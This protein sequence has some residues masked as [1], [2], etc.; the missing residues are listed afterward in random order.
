M[1]ECEGPTYRGCGCEWWWR[2]L[3]VCLGWGRG[4]DGLIRWMHGR[5]GSGRLDRGRRGVCVGLSVRGLRRQWLLLG[6]VGGRRGAVVGRLGVGMLRGLVVA[7]WW[8]L[9]LSTTSGSGGGGVEVLGVWLGRASG[10]HVGVLL[11]G[12]LLLLSGW[13]RLR[14]QGLGV[15]LRGRRGR[16]G[17]W[18]RGLGRVCMLC[19][20]GCLGCW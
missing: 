12:H 2:R 9:L 10:V 4:Q 3:V 17:V 18:L 7:G 8:L 14:I 11:V 19:W 16:V 13:G 15:R 1:R 6:G 20:R 5:Q